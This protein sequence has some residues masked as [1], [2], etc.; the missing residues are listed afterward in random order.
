MKTQSSTR[1]RTITLHRKDDCPLKFEGEH[2]GSAGTCEIE[3]DEHCRGFLNEFNLRTSFHLFKT[4]AGKYVGS[5]E[6]YDSTNGHYGLRH[7]V[8]ADTPE[9]LFESMLRLRSEFLREG[10]ITTSVVDSDI[11]RKL[12]ANGGLYG[13][14]PADDESVDEIE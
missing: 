6:E 4:T 10:Y 14:I 5:V 2:L 3:F 8:F 12:F 7:A 13:Q 9:K 11:L 1:T